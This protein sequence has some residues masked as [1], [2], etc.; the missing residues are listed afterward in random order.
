LELFGA[1]DQAV[2]EDDDPHLASTVDQVF[3]G[4]A[5]NLG[6]YQELETFFFSETSTGPRQRPDAAEALQRLSVKMFSLLPVVEPL[7]P[8][9]LKQ[10]L[11]IPATLWILSVW[12]PKN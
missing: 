7:P 6:W 2:I 1:F 9:G 8:D 12:V 3:P 10:G 11:P 4:S 5:A